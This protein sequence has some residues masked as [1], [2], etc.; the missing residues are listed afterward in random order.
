MSAVHATNVFLEE[1]RQM[2]EHAE[3]VSKETPEDDQ[4]ATFSGPKHQLEME[5][6]VLVSQLPEG[7]EKQ[8]LLGLWYLRCHLPPLC[9][10]EKELLLVSAAGE[11]GYRNKLHQFYPHRTYERNMM[12]QALAIRDKNNNQ[13]HPSRPRRH[14]WPQFHKQLAKEPSW[15]RKLDPESPLSYETDKTDGESEGQDGSPVVEDDLGEECMIAIAKSGN[16]RQRQDWLWF[17]L[18]CHRQGQ[19]IRVTPRV[20]N[21]HISNNPP[22]AGVFGLLARLP[23]HVINELPIQQETFNIAVS[24]G[25]VTGRGNEHVMVLS[26]VLEKRGES[27]KAT[28]MVTIAER[29]LEVKRSVQRLDI[30]TYR[31]GLRLDVSSEPSMEGSK[32]ED[33]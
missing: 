23:R 5:F 2:K 4:P 21:T 17:R 33:S 31:H 8:G 1:Y 32:I 6:D 14:S 10:E 9:A 12:G 22:A 16:L 7:V 30:D 26:M 20:L 15:V 28:R 13:I 24:E 18:A 25:N 27:D 3:N 29:N 19:V 11:G